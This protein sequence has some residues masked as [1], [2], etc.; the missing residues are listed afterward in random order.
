MGQR[1]TQGEA[2][3]LGVGVF[4]YLWRMAYELKLIRFSSGKESTLGLLFRTGADAK[5]VTHEFLCYTLEDEYRETKKMHETRIPAGKYRITLRKEGGFHAKTLAKYGA[6]FH[7]GMLWLRDVP[8]FEYILIHTGNDDTHSSGCILV[9]NSSEQNITKRGF[10]GAS[11]DAYAR[12]YPPIA[13]ALEAGQDVSISIVD[14][15]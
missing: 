1:E 13:A 10:I 8:G 6:G 3:A 4:I 5:G 15:A 2:V 11:G 9:G 12:I 7:K 14:L